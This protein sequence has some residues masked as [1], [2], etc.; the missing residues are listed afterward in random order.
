MVQMLHVVLSVGGQDF[1]R[2]DFFVFKDEQLSA[3]Q[4]AMSIGPDSMVPGRLFVRGRA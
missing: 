1:A 3:S 4:C 2:A